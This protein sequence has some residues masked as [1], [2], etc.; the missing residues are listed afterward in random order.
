[1]PQPTRI[2]PSVPTN[3][4]AQSPTTPITQTSLPQGDIFDQAIPVADVPRKGYA[5][6]LFGGNGTGKTTIACTFPKPLMVIRPEEV[7]DG[8]ESVRDVQGI[9]VTPPITDPDQL[10]TIAQRQKETGRYKTL[11]LDGLERFQDLVMKK[12]L[13]LQ[14]VP[15]QKTWL[16][17]KKPEWNQIGIAFKD[18]LRSILRLTEQGTHIVMTGGEKLLT[19][20]DE[21]KE[22]MTQFT[23]FKYPPS[24]VSGLVPTCGT[25]V[26]SSCHYIVHTFKRQGLR[27]ETVEVPLPTG[28]IHTE[29]SIIPTGRMQ[30]CAHVGNE[31]ELYAT[32]FRVSKGTVI[33]SI[34]VDPTYDKFHA[35]I[36]GQG[37][38][39]KTITK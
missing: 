8:T 11:V 35:I 20:S 1:M 37:R 16:A 15:V 7:E 13:G 17:V 24:V 3:R 12:H 4:V 34:M 21:M 39:N 23:N 22:L 38:V 36:M 19:A 14:D 33:E 25:F 6:V 18:L 26:H 29:T 5:F 30:F 2:N 10:A 28:G 9:K 31:V 27:E 32:K